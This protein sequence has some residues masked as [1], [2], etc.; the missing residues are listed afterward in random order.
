M[1]NGDKSEEKHVNEGDEPIECDTCQCWYHRK[2]L[3][4]VITKKL[5]KIWFYL[6]KQVRPNMSI[7]DA[8]SLGNFLLFTGDLRS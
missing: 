3:D 2:C 7:F 5:I 1:I 8:T 6:S 4:K